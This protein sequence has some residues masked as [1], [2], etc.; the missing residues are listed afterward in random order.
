MQSSQ[1]QPWGAVSVGTSLN[2]CLCSGSGG[3]PAPRGTLSECGTRGPL[4]DLGKCGPPAGTGV[5]D[6]AVPRG[7]PE[8]AHVPEVGTWAWPEPWT[9]PPLP[10]AGWGPAGPGRTLAGVGSATC[11]GEGV[12]GLRPQAPEGEAGGPAEPLGRV[13]GAGQGLSTALKIA[14]QPGSWESI[15]IR[16]GQLTLTGAGCPKAVPVS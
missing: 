8:G 1:L 3:G 11:T 5:G 16:H 7:L 2:L 10:W 15:G 6:R 13:P 14:L 4:R 12:W 9:R